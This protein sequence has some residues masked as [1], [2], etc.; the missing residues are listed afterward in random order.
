[1]IHGS[2]EKSKI[3][4]VRMKGIQNKK[5]YIYL[6]K[7]LSF[8]YPVYVIGMK[9]LKVYFHARHTRMCQLVTFGELSSDVDTT[10]AGSFR[11]LASRVA[12]S[13]L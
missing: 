6:R 5:K 11:V 12:G 8:T 4:G 1:V 10:G 13:Y 9:T 2:K 3:Q 7:Q